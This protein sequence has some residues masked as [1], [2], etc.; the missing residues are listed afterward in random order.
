LRIRMELRRAGV[1]DDVISD[2][3]AANV[4]A[5]GER[6]RAMATAEKKLP[7]LRRRNEPAAVRNK[8]TAYLLKQVYDAA[9]VRSIV[10]EI[11]VA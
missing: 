4:D 3:L 8:L 2:V 7:G 10:K 11:T 5:D 6:A 9:L 1:A